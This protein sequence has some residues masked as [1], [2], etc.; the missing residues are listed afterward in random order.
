MTID[1]IIDDG[2]CGAL[3]DAASGY[4]ASSNVWARGSRATLEPQ[5]YAGGP[6]S[7][8]VV[9]VDGL[10]LEFC[11]SLL[12]GVTVTSR[13]TLERPACFQC[14]SA[15]TMAAWIPI[16][17]DLPTNLHTTYFNTSPLQLDFNLQPTSTSLFASILEFQT[18]V[19]AI[20]DA[21]TVRDPMATH[22]IC[23]ILTPFPPTTF[24]GWHTFD[25]DLTI[26]LGINSY[27]LIQVKPPIAIF[28]DSPLHHRRSD[29]TPSGRFYSK[30]DMVPKSVLA[31]YEDRSAA[32]SY[33]KYAVL[34]LLLERHESLSVRGGGKRPNHKRAKKV[35]KPNE[36][37]RKRIEDFY[38]NFCYNEYSDNNF[39]SEEDHREIEAYLTNGW[40][41]YDADKDSMW[42]GRDV[43]NELV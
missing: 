12:A 5:A 8:L 29:V 35:R 39:F 41:G 17:L 16:L 37:Q 19:S 9:S 40:S 24:K 6:C 2:V 28:A 11:A 21:P 38:Y 10:E 7:R 18:P 42:A 22:P 43:R 25:S 23:S 33:A 14:Y 34:A 36:T 3:A 32:A 26:T 4:A 31:D 15:P 20:F 13:R 30:G 1:N 27:K